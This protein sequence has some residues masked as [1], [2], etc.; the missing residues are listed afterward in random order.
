MDVTDMR[1]GQPGAF[2]LDSRSPNRYD[3]IRV[4][5]TPIKSD[6]TGHAMRHLTMDLIPKQARVLD[7][8]APWLQERGYLPTF[9]ELA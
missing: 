8:T 2:S 3:H 7:F 1:E 5:I 6:Q 9:Q 4:I